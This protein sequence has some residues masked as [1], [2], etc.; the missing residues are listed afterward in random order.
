MFEMS[1]A[2]DQYYL[3]IGGQLYQGILTEVEGTFLY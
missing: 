1:K 3:V 2:A